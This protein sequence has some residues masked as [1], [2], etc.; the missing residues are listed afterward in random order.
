MKYVGTSLKLSPQR[1]FCCFVSL[2][3]GLT[4]FGFDRFLTRLDEAFWLAA[5]VS[6]VLKRIKVLFTNKRNSH[7]ICETKSLNRD[8]LVQA[9]I[10]CRFHCCCRKVLLFS[11]TKLFWFTYS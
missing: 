10:Y 2:I 4:G 9:S 5:V 7:L 1:Q 11:N 6:Y 3:S 8:V